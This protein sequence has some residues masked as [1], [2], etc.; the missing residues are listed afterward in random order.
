MRRGRTHQNNREEPGP[1]DKENEETTGGEPG[2][3]EGRERGRAK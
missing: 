1:D 3:T 2:Q